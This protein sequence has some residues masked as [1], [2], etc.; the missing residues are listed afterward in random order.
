ML[1]LCIYAAG[2]FSIEIPQLVKLFWLITTELLFETLIP[3][4]HV[5]KLQ[6]DIVEV[7]D[8]LDP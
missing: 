6:P 3:V 1:L 7:G 2:T 5:V 8:G 4:P